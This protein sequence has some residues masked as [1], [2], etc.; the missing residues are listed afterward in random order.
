MKKHLAVVSEKLK[1]YIY[2]KMTEDKLVTVFRDNII[3][4]TVLPTPAYRKTTKICTFKIYLMPKF[5]EADF[6]SLHTF[7]R[8]LVL[9]Y[10]VF[11][12]FTIFFDTV[13]QIVHNKQ[14][15]DK[16]SFF[17][18]IRFFKTIFPSFGR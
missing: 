2:D 10:S 18:K 17:K 3:I 6:F 16:I 8:I 7:L 14:I 4:K 5:K 12:P 9:K 11:I 15:T 13:Y 1:I